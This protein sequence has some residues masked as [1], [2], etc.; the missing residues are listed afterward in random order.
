MRV[1]TGRYK[2][3]RLFAPTGKNIRP[4]TDRTKEFL[5]SYLGDRIKNAYFLD[6]FAGTGG[7]GIEALSRNAAQVI[8]VD[9]S[10]RA[11]EFIR[12][13]LDK[14]G[15]RSPVYF[16]SEKVFLLQAIKQQLQFDFIFCDPPYSYRY[17]YD[18][19][20]S[21]RQGSLLK[22]NGSVIYES[23]A[24]EKTIL[25]EAFKIIK[26]K[27]LGDTKITIYQLNETE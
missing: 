6:L 3:H 16:K 22:E 27:I 19:L 2:G 15:E 14:V 10:Y 13:N 26:E 21:V 23:G 24:K 25:H 11:C 20:Q 17:F 18:L 8:F 7:V 1:I 12:K 4:T 9:S 5:F